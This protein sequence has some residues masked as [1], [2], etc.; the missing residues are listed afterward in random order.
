MDLVFNDSVAEV[1][2]R[3]YVVPCFIILPKYENPSPRSLLTFHVFAQLSHLAAVHQGLCFFLSD[4]F[5]KQAL[6]S[7]LKWKKKEDQTAKN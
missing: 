3:Q 1:L 7:F 5:C 4:L 2:L 6:L